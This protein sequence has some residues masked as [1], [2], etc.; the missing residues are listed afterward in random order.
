M[1][2]EVL[3]AIFVG[4]SMGLIITFGVYR[5][6]NTITEKPIT[7]LITQT[8]TEATATPTVLALHNPEDGTIQT[9]KE[10]TVTGTTIANTFIIVFVNDDDYVS[11]SDE[12]GNFA[13][14][15]SLVDAENFI[16]VHVIDENSSA[17]VE[18]RLVVVSDAFEKLEAA[19][20]ELEAQQATASAE[21]QDENPGETNE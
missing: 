3:I 14:K 15:V 9:E 19:Q 1:K 18:E 12:S 13:I 21:N 6:K 8:E 4:L 2:K 10:L 5:V 17:V 20:K 11:T 7:E 16:R